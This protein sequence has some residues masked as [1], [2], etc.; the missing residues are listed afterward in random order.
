MKWIKVIV[1]IG[2]LII[3]EL[4]KAQTDFR[5]GYIIANNGDTIFGEID[6][7]GDILMGSNCKFRS[8]GYVFNYSP[9]DIF[10]FRFTDS[11]FYVSREFNGKKVFLEYLINGRISIYYLRDDNGDHYYFDKED[12]PLKEIPYEEGIKYIDDKP[13]LYKSIRHIGL[14]AYYMQ[15]APKLQ[16]RIS[17]LKTPEHHNL[18]K[19]AEDYHNIFCKEEECIIYEKRSPL[20]ELS[21]EPFLGIIK[22]T[23]HNQFIT[24]FG[25]YT[26]IGAPSTNEKLYFKTG[27][28]YQEIADGGEYLNLFKIPLQI[29]Y[30]Y[31]ANRFMPKAS[32]GVNILTDR[33]LTFI[34]TL[35]INAG[36]GYRID[37][38]LGISIGLNTDFTPISQV[39]A[40][41]EL[42]FGIISYAFNIGLS[43]DL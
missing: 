32:I 40:N 35:S 41:K 11:K 13:Y 7:R 17:N 3:A 8:G 16:A 18:I 9:Y 6:Y 38:S 43:I 33:Y 23:G 15:D 5:S 14:L 2:F 34:H 19:L 20:V 10:A 28:G 26:Y 24:E 37:E 22:Y 1:P 4:I 30:I 42:K 21:L 39:I 31:H 12:V 25:C 29:Q 36:I 27:I